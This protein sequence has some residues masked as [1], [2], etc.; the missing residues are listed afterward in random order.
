[1]KDQW[2]FTLISEIKSII[3]GKGCSE[4]LCFFLGAGAD[5]TSGGMLF[6]DLKRRCLYQQGISLPINA[7]PL[8]IDCT[9]DQY[10]RALTE[11]ERC[12]VLENLLRETRRFNPSDGYRL[13]VLMAREKFV[14]SVITTNFDNLMEQTELDMGINAFQIYSPGISIPAS[15][16]INHRS[17]RAIYLKMHGDVD[18]RCVT[19][20]TVEEI[21]NRNYQDE[22]KILLQH[23][24]THST[25]IVAGYSGY[26]SKI[27]DIFQQNLDRLHTVYW[28]NPSL[29][30]P[31]APLVKV[32]NSAQK[33]RYIQTGFDAFVET[34]AS[35]LFRE[36]MIFHADSIFIWSLIKTKIE[37]LQDIY[38][39]SADLPTSEICIPRLAALSQFDQFLAQ[40]EK[41]LFIL[42]G[43]QGSGKTVLISQLLMRNEADNLYV[44]PI[45][46]PGA[47][48]PDPSAYLI[49]NLGYI[50]TNP[51]SVLYQFTEW[52]HEIKKDVVI[53]FD[54][55][56]SGQSSR[57][58]IADYL[59]T[60]IELAYIL[61]H[62]PNVKFI[63]SLKDDI[64]NNVAKDLD[65]NYLRTVLWSNSHS[66]GLSSLFMDGF[67]DEELSSALQIFR[68]RF[69][70][71]EVNEISDDIRSLFRIPFFF[72]L[73]LQHN[74]NSG[75]SIFDVA[76]L[77]PTI[78]RIFAIYEL[79][80]A[81]RKFLQNLA[82]KMLNTNN[83]VLRIDEI[84]FE[85]LHGLKQILNV[86]SDCVSF[87]HPLFWQYF[88][89][90]SYKTKQILNNG[91]FVDLNWIASTF[92]CETTER[93]I[94]ESFVL[95]L[96]D[97]EEID[98]VCNF[99]VRLLQENQCNS[100]RLLHVNK[101][102]GQVVDNWAINRTNDLLQWVKYVD[103]KSESFILISKRL[104]Y[105]STHMDDT[106]AYLLL[107]MLRIRCTNPIA[108]ECCVLINDRFSEGLKR[109]PEGEECEYFGKYGYI[110]K[111][112]TALGTL[113]QFVWL[114]S[115]IGIDNLELNHY[116]RLAKC[117]KKQIESLDVS[118]VTKEDAELLKEGFVQNVYMI[119][120]NANSNL[121]EKF[122]CFAAKSKTSPIIRTLL[123]GKDGITLQ[124]LYEIRSC[125]DHFDETIE[126]FV[127]NLLFTLSML[128]NP[129]RALSEL[130]ALY[131]S[132][133]DNVN[134]L[135]LDFYLSALF[136]SCYISDPR[137]RMQYLTRFEQTIIDYET[138]IFYTPADGR[139]SSCR[140]FSD[141]FDLEF[142]DGFNALTN[143][144]YTAPSINY[145]NRDNEKQGVDEYLKAYWYLLDTLETTG[146][147]EKILRLLQAVSQMIV[148]WPKE[149]FDALEKFV[150]IKH[151]LIHR[152]VVRVLS[153]NY[154]RYPS[155][156]KSFLNKNG[157]NFTYHE[158]LEIQGNASANIEY[159]TLEQLQWARMLYFLRT[160]IDAD[161]IEKVLTIFI[162][163][164]TLESALMKIIALTKGSNS[165]ELIG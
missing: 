161:I 2:Q 56:G 127:C 164:D 108:L 151:P 132:F 110:L 93:A 36:R 60:I 146:N 42:S 29:P 25:V 23:L 126:F 13:L 78:D 45:S 46:A 77:M 92:L 50:T 21:N 120:F 67:T 10:F 143:Y 128:Q 73:A 121:E 106:N 15:H 124:H 131:N 153:Q 95:F 66:L 61:R 5:I 130:D 109:V 117:V 83:S 81:E 141:Q 104:A 58:R 90:R 142:E 87:R 16:I 158:L 102:I 11:D 135:E 40:T 49:E 44:V 3:R 71:H 79:S 155:I 62:V 47:L 19:H 53:V 112:N 165:D 39:K 160:W 80:F 133:G 163:T 103:S 31:D 76:G 144:S 54:S 159:R 14:S 111:S 114:M 100:S 37:K 98:C 123:N 85:T 134:I 28:C 38:R 4:G 8:M 43:P 150:S 48:V 52:L 34:I 99:F 41:N 107:D 101:L 55:I 64:F 113:V 86:T 6:S 75:T 97:E 35:E 63:I 129:N 94:Q 116:T 149:G 125:V 148:N 26:D 156:T 91:T 30:N 27:A 70:A 88:L 118:N 51:M 137:E 162:T 59:S 138:L 22:Y 72:G 136:M 20:L 65:Q 122:Y 89:V 147:Y 119:F 152:G 57:E 84:E 18:G 33:L 96:S 9:F 157:D 12:I 17:S 74:F 69:T 145:I 68:Y 154:L 82:T 24:L 7:S 139:I 1:M 115:K 140:R 32:L 105:C